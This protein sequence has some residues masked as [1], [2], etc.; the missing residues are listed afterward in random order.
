MSFKEKVVIITGASS[1]I[2]AATAI[3]FA[4]EGAKVS[5]VGRNQ[6][7][8]ITVAGI[9][10][11]IGYKPLIV[12]ADVTRREDAKRIVSD[13]LKH[14]GK[15]DILINNAGMYATT[16]IFDPNVLEVH[17]RVMAINLHAAVYMTH[18][19][20]PHIV[21][22]KGNIIN[23]SSIGAKRLVADQNF[24][25]MASKAG[26]DH[27][28]RS[29][30]LELAPKGVRVNVVNPGPVRTDFMESLGVPAEHKNAV[31]DG[32]AQSMPLKRVAEPEEAAD[33]ILFLA[34]D[35]ARSI[36]GSSYVLDNGS[37]LLGL[38]NPTS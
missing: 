22:T 11:Q 21:A 32:I 5:M 18:L 12:I 19:T 31:F 33:L 34:S 35:K 9:C 8:L 26:L 30:A 23:I 27:F 29:M 36:T 10:E 1:G 38:M 14:F 25:C 6:T 16:S 24:S 28:S 37:L 17:D 13:T 7:K 3:A 2:G 15:L 4:T 20:A